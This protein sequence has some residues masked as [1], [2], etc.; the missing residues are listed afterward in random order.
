MMRSLWTA[1][2]GMIGQQT[3]VDTISNNLSNVNTIGYKSEKT[4]FKSL[5]Y[6]D[7]QAK[8]TTKNGENKPVPAQV[9][10]GT[11]VA[12]ITS[13]YTQGGMESTGRTTDF[14]ISGDG[15]FA[16]QNIGT[17]EVSYTRN[18]SFNWSTST[19]GMMLCTADGYPVLSSDGAAI[20]LSEEYEPGKITIDG[21]GNLL[22]PDEQNN[23]AQL[24]MKIALFQFSNPAGLDKI[25]GSY[26][27]Q[28]DASGTPLNEDYDAV[29]KK[30]KLSQGYV[31]MS[32]VQ[33]ATEMVNLITAQRAYE[34]CS[35][36]ITTSDTMMEQANNL[37][38]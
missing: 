9:G 23:P 14:A 18:G 12:A 35:K 6:Q 26:L 15:F 38:R 16:V 19:E 29:G 28:T 5:L 7:L 33:V 21:D 11:R 32:N 34:L 10:L 8:T 31:E 22:Y 4:E 2:S 13:H 3:A 20:V 1:A 25:G 30:S 17:G 37:K 24:G 36:A 27:Q